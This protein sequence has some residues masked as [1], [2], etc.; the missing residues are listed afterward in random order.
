MAIK[1]LKSLVSCHCLEFG[2]SWKRDNVGINIIIYLE[3]F[4]SLP[5][6]MNDLFSWPAENLPCSG[7]TFFS[8][9]VSYPSLA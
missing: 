6:D 8:G 7:T 3:V 1:L 4:F 2:L 5:A 9:K